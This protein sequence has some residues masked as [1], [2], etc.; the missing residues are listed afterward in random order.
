MGRWRRINGC[1]L[2]P[3]P[4][5][6]RIKRLV[7]FHALP[8]RFVIPLVRVKL[9]RHRVGNFQHDFLGVCEKSS[10]SAAGTGNRGNRRA[11]VDKLELLT[12]SLFFKKKASIAKYTF[13]KQ[14]PGKLSQALY[15]ILKNV[16]LNTAARL[17][18][19]QAF[20][21]NGYSP[22]QALSPCMS[23]VPVQTISETRSLH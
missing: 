20:S 15:H 17:A 19:G 18:C 16:Y 1:V 11:L 8:M 14:V 5:I 23:L 2:Y 4:G 12:K 21:P 3:V 13:E 9:R 10:R 6:Q 7:A 22:P